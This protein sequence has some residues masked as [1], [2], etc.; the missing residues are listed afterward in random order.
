M[1][2]PEIVSRGF[3]YVREAEDMMDELREITA[4]V[5][6]ECFDDYEKDLTV[7]KGRIKDEV[8]K[9]IYQKTKRRPMVLPV[10]MGI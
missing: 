7:I 3:I 2:I 8:S 10:L 6:E 4:G 9:Y 5:I 1:S